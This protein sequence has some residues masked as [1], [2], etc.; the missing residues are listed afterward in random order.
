MAPD[1]S[2]F[3]IT[4]NPFVLLAPANREPGFYGTGIAMRGARKIVP[5]TQSMCLIMRDRG[6]ST[7]HKDIDKEVAKETNLQIAYF[8]DRF[9]IG[10]DKALVKRNVEKGKT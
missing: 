4:D 7:V 5:L 10:R 9:V 3:I 1:I 2:S 6:A 8:S